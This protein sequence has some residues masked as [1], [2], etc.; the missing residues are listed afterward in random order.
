MLDYL[1]ALKAE[2][3][4]EVQ[5]AWQYRTGL[6]SDLAVQ[7]LLYAGLLLSGRFSW[8]LREY[9][10][11]SSGS[12]SLLLIGFVFWSYAIYAIGQMGNE[13]NKE[14][15]VGT[16]EQKFMGVVP[17]P[18]LLV[19]KAIG[20]TIV[21]STLVL[22]LVGIILLLFK[23]ELNITLVVPFSLGV[24]LIG[25]YGLGFAF[26]GLAL[27]VKRT[28]Q[29]VFLVQIALL[30]LTGTIIPVN[31]L[32]PIV[33]FL[34]KLIPLTWGIDIARRSVGD[35]GG[36]SVYHWLGLIAASSVS[37]IF[38]LVTFSL[39]YDRARRDGLLGQY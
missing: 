39:A 33:G 16:L 30:F 12:R 9:G 24:T 2:I 19:G 38:G 23:L 10:S 15:M 4:R 26:A 13:I 25:M 27:L 29:L 22:A 1:R 31:S 5:E 6:L 21:S 34:G 28:G 7:A 11:R 3:V 17:P 20:G 8:L 32:P 18:L 36:I 14:A 37:L 35:V